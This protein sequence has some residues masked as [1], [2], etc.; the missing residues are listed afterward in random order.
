MKNILDLATEMTQVEAWPS[1]P[2][3]YPDDLIVEVVIDEESAPDSVG[4]LYEP[5]DW[6]TFQATMKA[7]FEWVAD[8]INKMASE[9]RH[10]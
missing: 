6:E 2:S 8:T 10:G 5:M 3:L 1:L 4:D 9:V 7:D